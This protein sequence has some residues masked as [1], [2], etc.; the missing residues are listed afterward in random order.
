MSAEQDRYHRQI[1]LPEIGK[2][3]Q[4]KLNRASILIVGAGGLGCPAAQYLTAA[5]VG[6]IG[7]V[8]FDR[9]DLSNLHRQVLFSEADVGK[10]KAEAAKSRLKQV[11]S[12]VEIRAITEHFDKDNALRLVNEYDI[13]LD[14]TD[15]FQTKY[16]INDACVLAGKP[17]VSASVYKYQGQV[18]VFNYQ[19]GPS[20]RCLYP[21]HKLKD[22]SSCEE[23]GVLGVLP[24]ILGT[25][26]AA[27]AIKITLGIGKVLSGKLKVIDTFSGADQMISF[28]RNEEQIGFVKERGLIPEIVK[29]EIQDR[30]ALYLDVREVHEQPQAIN[31]NVMRIPLN[32]LSGRSS[33]IPRDKE[34]LVFCQT[35]IRSLRAIALLEKEYG[36]DNLVNVEGGINML[37]T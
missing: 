13:I 25:I 23:T 7:L 22:E 30:S 18:S 31:E 27:E 1:K 29:C 8:D 10:P 19:G 37:M 33:E 15:N 5:G 21:E 34:V 9:V 16:M 20:Y 14:G 2:S 28:T 17:F 36:F 32:E 24:G 35:G 6:R 26:Q 11:N 4:E 12:A 3:G